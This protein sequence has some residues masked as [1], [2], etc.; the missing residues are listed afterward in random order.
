MKI[1]EHSWSNLKRVQLQAICSV[2]LDRRYCAYVTSWPQCSPV[3]QLMKA[4]CL[5]TLDHKLVQL[6][7]GKHSCLQTLLQDQKLTGS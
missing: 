6:T 7:T 4:I 2:P 3:L 5:N 1:L